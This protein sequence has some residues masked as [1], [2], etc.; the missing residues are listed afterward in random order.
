MIK[1]YT[2]SAIS[3]SNG[4]ILYVGGFGEGNYSTI[5]DAIK[6]AD[7]GDTVRIEVNVTTASATS[8]ATFDIEHIGLLIKIGIS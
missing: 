8:G 4:K 6:A 1:G 2:S 3:C 7:D 5:C